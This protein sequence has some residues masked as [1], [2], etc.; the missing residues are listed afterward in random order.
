MCL[1][2]P[3]SKQVPTKSINTVTEDENL[4]THA[5]TKS[6]DGTVFNNNYN[7][8]ITI[9]YNYQPSINEF[10][11]DVMGNRDENDLRAIRQEYK[12]KG[13]GF[14]LSLKF[15]TFNGK[16]PKTKLIVISYY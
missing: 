1:S 3:S 13:T 8:L 11:R 2:E 12:K 16:I 10:L 9:A 15:S 7:P 4:Q 14:L 6:I 5:K